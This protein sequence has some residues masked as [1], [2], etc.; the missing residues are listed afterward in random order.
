MDRCRA[1]DH[2]PS[3]PM[4]NNSYSAIYTPTSP[5]LTPYNLNF[6]SHPVAAPS[7]Y[8]DIVPRFSPTQSRPRSYF[9]SDPYPED[10]DDQPPSPTSSTRNGHTTA[11]DSLR[12]LATTLPR[13][14]P[15]ERNAPPSPI[16]S[17]SRTSSSF[18]NYIPFTS[19]K[20]ASPTPNLTPGNSYTNLAGYQAHASQSYGGAYAARGSRED[21]YS[22]A[23]GS[24]FGLG[25]GYRSTGGMGM[26]RPLP[27][28]GPPGHRP[29]SLDLV[30]PFSGI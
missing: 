20:T 23:S 4:R 17:I 29:R 24:G 12:E 15:R 2:A 30:T 14:A 28:R 25:D 3:Q 8:P 5:P 27:P 13:A 22:Y 6:S 11:L 26:D 9:S 19:S 10:L 1:V 21:L 18:F 16:S 7:E